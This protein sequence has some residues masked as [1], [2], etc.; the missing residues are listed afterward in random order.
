MMGYGTEAEDT[1]SLCYFLTIYFGSR[2]VSL[3]V[4]SELTA[5]LVKNRTLWSVNRISVPP[6][7]SFL[8]FQ[9]LKGKSTNEIA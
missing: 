7:L 2:L 5:S 3:L 8:Q 1:K 4:D 9:R 6:P